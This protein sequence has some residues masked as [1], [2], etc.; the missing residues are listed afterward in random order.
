MRDTVF[1]GKIFDFMS[2][3]FLQTHGLL[4]NSLII[5]M[6][7]IPTHNVLFFKKIVWSSVSNA[8]DKS[9]NILMGKRDIC[10]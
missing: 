5:V 1:I 3:V 2:K 6:L 10:L 9:R 7:R 8:F 4:R